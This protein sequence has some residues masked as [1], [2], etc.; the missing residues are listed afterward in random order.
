MYKKN[1]GKHGNKSYNSRVFLAVV[2]LV[3]VKKKNKKLIISSK[4]N[5]A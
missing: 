4:T 5:F 1:K 3:F 2:F